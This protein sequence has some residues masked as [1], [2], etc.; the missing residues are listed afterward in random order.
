MFGLFNK[1][2][3]VTKTGV[4]KIDRNASRALKKSSGNCVS[5]LKR[6]RVGKTLFCSK[7]HRKMNY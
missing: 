7:C 6:T 3:T 5:C 4:K 2:E 1:S